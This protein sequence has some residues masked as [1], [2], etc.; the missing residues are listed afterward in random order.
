VIHLLI[1]AL[2]KFVCL[3]IYLHYFLYLYF[4]PYLFTSLLIY[5]T[6]SR[7][8]VGM[9]Q[10]PLIA[11]LPPPSSLSYTFPLFPFL[12]ASSIFLLSICC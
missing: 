10:S 12:L 6:S 8:H 2:Y 1:L 9:G 7:P 3:F 5:G 4:L 11:S